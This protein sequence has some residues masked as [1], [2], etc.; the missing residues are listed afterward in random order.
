MTI[1]DAYLIVDWSANSSPKKG[2]DSIWL[3]NATRS[4]DGVAIQTENLCTRAAAEARAVALL[5][6]HVEA[7]RRVLVGFDFPYGYP[8]GFAAMAAF[9]ERGHQPW[10]A[11]WNYLAAHIEDDERNVNNRFAVA[12][13]LNQSCG[14]S[15]GPFWGCPS[16]RNWDG[17]S[18]KGSVWPGNSRPKRYRHTEAHLRQRGQNVQEV[19]KL[20]TTGSVGS[21]T[22]LGIPRVRSLRR[23][24]GLEP[25]SR[26]WPFETGFTQEPLG[27]SAPGVLHAE[28]WPGV[29]PVPALNGRVK[30]DIQ[31]EALA[32]HLA[33]RDQDGSLA[34]LFDT[35]A[36]LD[37]TSL[38][39]CVDEEGWILG[40]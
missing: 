13:T 27:D 32:R 35:P 8:S 12:A 28:I 4:S 2:K 26:V 31:V 34:A 7:S 16:E 18:P 20:W 19:W 25:L 36:G 29:V 21:Q 9:C 3:A 11:T 30:D 33:G 1:F 37:P 23:H 39:E 6:G 40:A 15:V 10:R 24:P 14:R 38:E 17:L 5:R 22:L